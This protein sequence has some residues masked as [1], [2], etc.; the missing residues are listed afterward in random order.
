MGT[1]FVATT[2]APVHEDDKRQIVQNTERD[3]VIIFREFHNSARVARHSISEEIA[4]IPRRPGATFADV[5][6]LASGRR[7]RTLVLQDGDMEWRAVFGVPAR[8]RG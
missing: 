7:G 4:E 8:L 2:E 6:H 3:T 1:R 5:T